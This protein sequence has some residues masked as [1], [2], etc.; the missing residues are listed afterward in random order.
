MNPVKS[1]LFATAAGIGLLA[2]GLVSAAHVS[3][4][5]SS[6]L[7]DLL[8]IDT[9]PSGNTGTQI[10]DIQICSRMEVGEE[11]QID[12]VVRGVPEF[13]NDSGGLTGIDLKIHFDER[14]VHMVDVEFESLFMGV[15]PN[16]SIVDF[17][18]DLPATDGI[19]HL[20]IAD[21]GEG[22]EGSGEGAVFRV[23][24]EGVGQGTSDLAIYDEL[25]IDPDHLSQYDIETVQSGLIAVG[26][27]CD[28]NATPPPPPANPRTRTPP[29]PDTDDPDNGDT[30]APNGAV[31]TNGAN[32]ANGTTD[33]PDGE[34]PRPGETVTPRTGSDIGDDGED[35]NG[36]SSTAIIIALIVTAL[37]LGLAGAGFYALRRRGGTEV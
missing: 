17:T 9:D 8:A 34:T 24:L 18:Q 30:D 31:P 37:V 3:A 28:P 14:Y 19:L 5:T 1:L 2:F 20:A 15:H 16:S 10:G 33:D 26:V 13:V 7:V 22:A 35:D 27:D 23:T 12:V 29:P 36:G 11:H 4:Q 6:G 25:M 21:F 32:G